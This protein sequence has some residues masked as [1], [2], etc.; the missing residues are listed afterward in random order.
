[1]DLGREATAADW[2]VPAIIGAALMMQ[3][4]NA[5]V[6]TNALPAMATALE[7]DPLRLN[8]AITMYMLAAAVFL[9]VSGWAADRFG[10]RRVFVAAIILYAL[11]S[12]ACG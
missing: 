8:L 9:P 1:M 2:R 3:T 11:A 12:A 4:L 7:V 5:T 10:A 6:L